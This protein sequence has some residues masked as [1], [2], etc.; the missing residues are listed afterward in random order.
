LFEIDEFGL[1]EKGV[2]RGNRL[3]RVLRRIW[4]VCGWLQGAD[5][6]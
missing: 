1:G 5:W 3:R 2:G 6:R 4:H